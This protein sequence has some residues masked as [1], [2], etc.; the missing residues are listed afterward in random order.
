MDLANNGF[1]TLL[2]EAIGA[3]NA[4]VALSAFDLS[5]SVSIRLNPFKSGNTDIQGCKVPWS[6]YGRFLKDRPAFTLDPLFHA[7]AYYVQDSSSMFVGHIFR[8]VLKKYFRNKDGIIRVLDLCAAPGGK[9]TDICAS[10]REFCGDSFLLVSNEVM[11]NRA[12]VLADNIALWGDPNVAASSDDPSAF[13][14]LAGFFDIIV[15]DVPCSGEGMFRKDEDALAQWSEDNVALC[16]ARQKR[17]IADVWQALAPGGILIYSTCTFNKSENDDNVAWITR[18]FNAE[19]VCLEN[20]A[21]E[22]TDSEG[23]SSRIIRTGQGFSLVPGLVRGEGQY[24]SAV[25]KPE[26]TGNPAGKQ[27]DQAKKKSDNSL[28][29]RNLPGSGKLSDIRK[30]SDIRKISDIRKLLD[31]DVEILT[32]GDIIKAIPGKI[33]PDLGFIASKLHIIASGCAVGRMKGT[34]FVPDADLALSIMLSDNAFLSIELD[35][36]GALAFLHK[37]PI[38]L[39]DAPKGYILLKHKGLPLGFVKNIGTRCNSLHPQNR[40]I[41]MDITDKQ[42]NGQTDK[43][44][45]R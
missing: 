13:S 5:V 35:E 18:E 2:E 12:S 25:K 20:I 21:T 14:G 4:S 29:T 43:Q 17:I 27:R 31:T 11:K 32:K 34:D 26:E 15:A 42:T 19:R 1:K 24:C 44:I 3:E 33:A 37:D 10:L 23:I 7:G 40:R 38:I 30:A 39:K 9:T 28:N 8:E 41:R 22:Y 36:P 16:A 45:N 6:E